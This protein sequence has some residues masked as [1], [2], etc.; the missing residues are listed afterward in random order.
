MTD[1]NLADVF[2]NSKFIT[3]ATV[4]EDGSPWATPLGWFAFDAANGRIVFDNHAGT[5]HAENLARDPRCFIS[6]VNYEQDHSRSAYIK[7]VAHKL[8]GTEYVTAKKM[9]LDKGLNVTNDIFAAPIGEVDDKKSKISRREDGSL[10][11]YCY[12]IYE[13]EK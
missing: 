1:Q 6:I 5:I 8:T 12:M 2:N 7:T 3:I 11:F 4:C 9:I 10:R 13:E